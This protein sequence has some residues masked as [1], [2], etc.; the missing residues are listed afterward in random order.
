PNSLP[1]ENVTITSDFP[2]YAADMI[3]R[4]LGGVA[5]FTNGAQGS[6]DIEGFEGR[7]FAGVERRGKALGN[8]VLDVC[9]TIQPEPDAVIRA[10]CHSFSMPYRKVPPETIAWA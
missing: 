8:A 2:G 3:E 5:L 6:V 10:A 4:A 7:D 9:R 1:G